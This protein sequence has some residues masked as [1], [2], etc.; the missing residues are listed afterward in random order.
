M[1]IW[2]AIDIRGGNCVRL[3]QGDY[4]QEKVYGASP[5]DMAHRFVSDGATGLH[6]VD[7]DGARDG[8]NPNQQE[9]ATIAREISIP[10]QLGGGIRSEEI[11]RQYLDAGIQRLVIGTRALTHRDWFREMCEKFPE[12]LLV[13]IDA[14]DGKVSTDGW[15]KTSDTTA[16][17]LATQLQQNPIAG[18]VYT[19]IAKDGM[20]SGPNL[21]AMQEMAEAISK[22]L[23]ASG[24]VTTIQDVTQLAELGLDG[25]IIGRAI[26]EGK[27]SVP[28]AIE[29]ARA[30]VAKS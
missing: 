10:C 28:K 2:P 21:G 11:I 24:G 13:G 8:T 6:I 17:E 23:I 29:A 25:C 26:Y 7:L 19:D 18:I 12:R 16:V 22:P 20:M 5:V 27:L 14:R 9:I 4:Q 3:V 1:Q 15:Q 30:A